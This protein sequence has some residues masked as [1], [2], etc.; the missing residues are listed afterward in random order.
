MH[1]TTLAPPDSYNSPSMAVVIPVYPLLAL[2]LAL[3]SDYVCACMVPV[4][5][6]TATKLSPLVSSMSANHRGACTRVCIF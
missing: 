4:S 2:E 3:P 6:V 1:C 5:C